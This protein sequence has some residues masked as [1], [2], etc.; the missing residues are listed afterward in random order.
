MSSR[1]K[2]LLTSAILLCAALWIRLSTL[3]SI[4]VYYDEANHLAW[5]HSFAINTSS[6]PLLMDG[7]FLMGIIVSWFNSQGWVTLWVGRAAT[8]IFATLSCAACI[9][10][11]SLIHSR[12]TG[13]LAGVLYSVLPFSL[14]H[15]KQVL[16]DPY[17][18]SF[19]ALALISTI[20][21]TRTKQAWTILLTA[22]FLAMSALSKLFGLMYFALPLLAIYLLRPVQKKKRFIVK[23]MLILLLGLVFWSSTLW[24]L[25]SRLGINN[26]ELVNEQVGYIGCPPLI[27][28][29]DLGS[30]IG[31]F[32][33]V[34]AI[35]TSDVIPSYFGWILIV[36]SL[37]APSFTPLGKRREMWFMFAWLVFSLF[38]F[39][40][41]SRDLPPRYLSFI[42]VPITIL[43]ATTIIVLVKRFSY[44]GAVI[45]FLALTLWGFSN[46]VPLLF[47][48]D[49]A[50]LP[51]YDRYFYFTS[52]YNNTGLD[53]ACTTIL[54][55][56]A[57]HTLPSVVIEDGLP[58]LAVT[59]YFDRSRVDVRAA[60]EV[61]VGDVR[62]WL[63][64]GQPIYIIKN[65]SQAT[66]LSKESIIDHLIVENIGTYPSV[67]GERTV[68]LSIVKS[69]DDE[70]RREIFETVFTKPASLSESYRSLASNLPTSQHLT[71]LAYP[72]TQVE[73]FKT[74]LA[75][76]PIINVQ[77]IGKTWP[78]DLKST[79]AS[80][81]EITKSDDNF[82]MVFL[83]E[84]KG[85][86]NKLIETWLNTNLFK[87]DEQWFGPIRMIGYAGDSTV[88][89]THTVGARFGDGIRLESVEVIDSVAR[90]GEIARLRLIWKAESAVA[91]D[92]KSFTHIFTGDKIIAQRDGQPVGELRP[93]TTWKVGEMI[94]D[95]FA[96]RIPLDAPGGIYQL[97]VGLYDVSTQERLSV[98]GGNDFVIVGEITIH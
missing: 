49:K 22:I 50:R 52:V 3:Y 36:L 10:G 33:Y 60:S 80:L 77:G 17:M 28:Q 7:K 58:Y 92:F 78:L 12:R 6:Y 15:D 51:F 87:I 54:K 53:L 83:D 69:V 47:K 25:S 48:P 26:Q 11:G 9:A 21:F 57:L 40:L 24:A 75:D 4:P 64:A 84:A 5:A 96:I 62:D 70:L 31:F 55:R 37:L 93:T 90:R 18:A 67:K 29:I 72:P 34:G 43:G 1:L 82:L 94:R 44:W 86:P 23:S 19:G 56:E 73:M 68:H 89:Q 66:T 13:L 61:Y 30:Q 65:V 42:T 2:F 20:H 59:A 45:S 91:R 14:F 98:N 76:K 71:L 39:M 46:D 85:D 38:T 16:A 74:L 79:F 81:S 27:C 88:T 32:K 95:Q 63:R 8:V 97:R 41:F 35:I